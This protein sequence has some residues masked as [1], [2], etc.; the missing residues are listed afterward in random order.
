MGM[1]LFNVNGN[2]SFTL[3]NLNNNGQFIL[4]VPS[5]D[6]GGSMQFAGT[7]TSNLSIAN[8]VDFQIGTVDFTI[9][10]WQ[11]QT[12]NNS[13]PRI[14]AIGNYPSTSIGVS[15]EGGTFYFWSNGSPVSFG[16]ATPYKNTW[17]H[18]AIT[19]SGSSLRVFKNGTQLSTTRTNTTNFNNT[20]SVLRIANESTTSSGAS[21]GGRITNFHWVKGFAKYTAPFTVASTPFTPLETTSLLLRATTEN[22][23]TSDSSSKSKLIMNN[24]VTWSSLTPFTS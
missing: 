8:D 4:S 3:S 20:T 10:W 23:V 21:F 7:S 24:N 22:T 11:F 13:F 17:V 9:E 18:F 19:R 6:V 16:S 14:F 15:I 2:G 1:Q 12:D 5:V